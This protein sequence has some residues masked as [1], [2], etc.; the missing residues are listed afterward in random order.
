M[1]EVLAAGIPV[2][3]DAAHAVEAEYRGRPVGALGRAGAFSFYATK[4]ITTGEGGMLTTDDGELAERA[5][6]LALHGISRDAWKRYAAGAYR[7]WDVVAAGYKYNMFDIQAA[8]GLEQLKKVDR[9]WQARRRLVERYDAALGDVP[10]LRLM[11]R[12]P[13]VKPSYHLYPVR[14][15]PEAPVTRDALMAALNERGIGV[16]VHFRAVH[17]HPYYREELGFA[18]GLCPVAEQAGEQ[19]VSLPLFPDMHDADIDRVTVAVREILG[20]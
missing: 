2:I 4:N 8:I 12:R 3:E 20:G 18:P 16:G 15:L 5:A 1:D 6:T 19:L 11:A 9:F 10:G 7:H 13:Y 17:L 14:V